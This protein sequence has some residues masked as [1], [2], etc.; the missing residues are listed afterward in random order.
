[1]MKLSIVTKAGN[2]GWIEYTDK[3][4]AYISCVIDQELPVEYNWQDE[5]GN[6]KSGW[7]VIEEVL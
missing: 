3:D 5:N 6:I 1:M 7:G 2:T 4:C